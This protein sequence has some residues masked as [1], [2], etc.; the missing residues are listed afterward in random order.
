MSRDSGRIGLAALVWG[1]LRRS[2]WQTAAGLFAGLVA[3]GALVAA[4][5]LLSGMQ[6]L[7][8][9]GLETLGGEVVITTPGN[10]GA[11]E[12]WLQTGSTD[13]IEAK[14]DVKEWRQ[15]LKDGN[16]LGVITTEGYDLSEGGRGRVSYPMASFLVVKLEF[17]ASPMMAFNEITAAIPEVEIVVAEQTTRHVLRD[18][19]PLVRHLSTASGIALL[20][21]VMITGLLASIRVGERRAELGMLRA[22]GATRRF[23]ISLTLA[24]SLSLAGGGALLGVVIA[25]GVMALL[26]MS[27]GLF[28]FLTALDLIRLAGTAVLATALASTLAALGPALQ[29]ARLD[30]LDAVRRNR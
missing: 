9:A 12:R 27:G 10:H 20:A 6:A 24:E 30:P 23:M 29:T 16:V 11:V 3:A 28:R 26:P 2:R 1:G 8:D 25:L 4:L 18:L 17:W 5:S 7:L 22:V 21:G 15:K 14:V 19:Q 13:P